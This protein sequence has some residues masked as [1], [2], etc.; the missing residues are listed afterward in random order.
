[1]NLKI[2]FEEQPI[3]DQHPVFKNEQTIVAS[4]K[5]ALKS[6]LRQIAKL[7]VDLWTYLSGLEQTTKVMLTQSLGF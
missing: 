4:D 7:F 5:L 6:V 3:F 2:D 1:M